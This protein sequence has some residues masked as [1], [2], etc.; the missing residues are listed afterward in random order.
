MAEQTEEVKKPLFAFKKVKRKQTVR[1]QNIESDED[2][3]GEQ[4]QGMAKFELF[5]VSCSG[6][7]HFK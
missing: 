5:K 2:K 1:R 3:K 4:I 6:F 7:S